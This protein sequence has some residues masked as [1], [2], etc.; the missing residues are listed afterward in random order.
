MPRICAIC[1]KGQLVGRNVSHANNKTRK[2]SKPNLHRARVVI[3]GVVKHAKVCTRCLRSGKA[4]K[5]C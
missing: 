2:V 4:K 1:K 5:A 3:D